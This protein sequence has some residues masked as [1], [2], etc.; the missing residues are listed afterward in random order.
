MKNGLIAS[1][2]WVAAVAVVISIVMLAVFIRP[3]PDTP[4]AIGDGRDPTT[5]GFDLSVT[6]VV[7]TE[8]VASGMPRDGLSAL[9]N[10]QTLPAASIPSENEARRGNL[11]VSGDRI[12]GLEINGESRAYP[13]RF[14]RWHQ[15]VNDTVGGTHV[16][17]TYCPLSDSVVVFNRNVGQTGELLFGVSGLMLDSDHLLYDRGPE[18]HEPSLWSPIRA[19]AVTGPLTGSDL[20]PLPCLVT[21]WAS[22]FDQHPE[23]AVLAPVPDMERLYKKNPYHSYFASDRLQFPVDPLPPPSELRLKDRVAALSTGGETVVLALPRLAEVEGATS[24]TWRGTIGDEPIELDWSLD[25]PTA[26]P[27]STTDAAPPTLVFSCWFAWH[28]A[29]PDGPDPLPLSQ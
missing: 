5:Y 3:Q 15:V 17:V 19:A 24:G 12:V 13:L 28:A 9:D 22:W 14:L 27:R 11:L 25:P 16:A 18:P 21:T 26:W 4:P 2:W 6:S 10:P 29:H 20:D 1:G 7:G 23:G 8:I